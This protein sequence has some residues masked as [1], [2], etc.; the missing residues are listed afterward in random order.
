MGGKVVSALS[1][2]APL[3]VSDPDISQK[4]Q[5]LLHKQRSSRQ[6]LARQKKLKVFIY[7][8]LLCRCI[9]LHSAHS[10]ASC[11]ADDRNLQRGQP[12][13]YHQPGENARFFANILL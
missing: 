10:R 6:S 9:C 13:D 3:W 4:S 12:R 8:F 2:T 5:E 1:F 7:I 11:G